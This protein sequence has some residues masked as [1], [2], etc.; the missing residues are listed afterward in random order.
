[1]QSRPVFVAMPV[2]GGDPHALAVANEAIKFTDRTRLTVLCDQETAAKKIVNM[3]TNSRTH[4]TVTVNIPKG[5][6]ASAGDVQ[7]ANYEARCG[8]GTSRCTAKPWSSTTKCCLS[9]CV[10]QDGRSRTSWSRHMARLRTQGLENILTGYRP[11]R[12]ICWI[13]QSQVFDECLSQCHI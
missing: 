11:S 9:S 3:V 5:C 10:L 4:E 13:H 6:R 7:R 12:E 1:M 8:S 2:K